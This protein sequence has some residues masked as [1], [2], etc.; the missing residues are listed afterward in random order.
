MENIRTNFL[1]H[2]SDVYKDTLLPELIM[3]VGYDAAV[4]LIK[5]LGGKSVYIPSQKDLAL[6]IRNTEIYEILSGVLPE[7]FKKVAKSLA[8]KYE[9]QYIEVKRIFNRQK[10]KHETGKNPKPISEK[11]LQ[12]I[13]EEFKE[14]FL[15]PYLERRYKRIV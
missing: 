8:S 11:Q 12:R 2:I 15:T 9:I 3:C 6:I 10:Q 13:K 14:Y 7:D 5:T 1:D 4:M